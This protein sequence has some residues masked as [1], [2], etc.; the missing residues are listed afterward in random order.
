[1][2]NNYCTLKNSK[3]IWK[4][5]KIKADKVYLSMNNKKL[6]T[7]INDIIILEN[8]IPEKRNQVSITT[9]TNNIASEIMLRHMT[10]LDAMEKLDKFIDTAIANHL[11]KVKIIHGKNGGILRQAVHEYLDNNPYISS[12][13]FGDYYEGGFGVTIAYIKSEI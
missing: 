7:D 9:A 4:I 2:E 3:L 13:N 5:E 10:K 11:P 1:M 8:Y 6:C 12:Y